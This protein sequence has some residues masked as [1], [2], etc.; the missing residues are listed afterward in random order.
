MDEE[1]IAKIPRAD[2]LLGLTW[3]LATVAAAVLGV[4]VV[5][6]SSIRPLLHALGFIFAM[7]LL[8]LVQWLVLRRTLAVSAWWIAAT[9]LGLAVT[10]LGFFYGSIRYFWGAGTGLLLALIA[11]GLLM[12]GG[13]QSIVL[14]RKLAGAIWWFVATVIST[15]CLLILLGS[16]TIADR[17]FDFSL[18]PFGLV[19]TYGLTSGL[20]LVLLSRHQPAARPMSTRF[21]AVALTGAVVLLLIYLVLS[22]D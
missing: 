2:W 5:R 21:T 16:E 7:I 17:V 8:A 11:G 19:A 3:F 12:L 15:A 14:R 9:A 20:I 22:G 4:V 13:L 1:Q 18:A 6:L 10:G